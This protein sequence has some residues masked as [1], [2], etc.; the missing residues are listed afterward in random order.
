MVL[1]ATKEPVEVSPVV[2]WNRNEFNDGLPLSA[3]AVHVMSTAVLAPPE[4]EKVVTSFVGAVIVVADVGAVKP[5]QG[6]L[7]ADIEPAHDIV[8]PAV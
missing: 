2:S 7:V 4:K 6:K 1:I 5:D 8:P 3:P